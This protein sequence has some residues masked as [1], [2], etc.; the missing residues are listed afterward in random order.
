MFRLALAAA[1]GFVAGVAGA[2]FVCYQMWYKNQKALIN[3]IGQLNDYNDELVEAN[4]KIW[5]S[6]N[7]CEEELARRDSEELY[8]ESDVAIDTFDDDDALCEE[9]GVPDEP[10]NH[11][12]NPRF[13][14]G[15]DWDVV[16]FWRQLYSVIEVTHHADGH[17]T[18]IRQGF[19]DTFFPEQAG[20]NGNIV[21]CLA[22]DERAILDNVR[23][24]VFEFTTIGEE[25]EEPD[26]YPWEV[27]EPDVDDYAYF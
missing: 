17:M 11:C 18:Y 13:I 7:A 21:A 19:E 15:R 23:G 27:N 4:E 12:P 2:T 1:L 3:E 9:D 26:L 6:Y 5:N 20:G 25:E 10:V 22:T 16:E 14:I 24:V 8:A